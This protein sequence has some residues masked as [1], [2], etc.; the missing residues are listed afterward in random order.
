[1]GLFLRAPVEVL[2]ARVAGRTEA[3]LRAP[4]GRDAS[5]ATVDV[6]ERA[7]L[8]DPGPLGAW[9]AVDAS[10]DPRPAARA[11]LGLPA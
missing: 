11:L 6:M 3:G 5:D 10:A 9:H 7:A 8:A 4:G 2:R 1:T